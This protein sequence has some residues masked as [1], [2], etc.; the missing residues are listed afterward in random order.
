MICRIRERMNPQR[1]EDLHCRKMRNTIS[2]RPLFCSG[3][4]PILRNLYQAYRTKGGREVIRVLSKLRNT[5]R[6]FEV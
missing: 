2:F 6:E 3:D 4:L 1:Q 5:E